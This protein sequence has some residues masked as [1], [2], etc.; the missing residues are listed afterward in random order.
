VGITDH[1]YIVVG[2]TF[3]FTKKRCHNV[4]VVA[5]AESQA[6]VASAPWASAGIGSCLSHHVEL[7]KFHKVE[8]KQVGR[9]LP[10]LQAKGMKVLR[11][12]TG[13]DFAEVA[14]QGLEV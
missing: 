1:S 14:L 11:N 6:V 3:R 8:A 9:D 5:A 12:R 10:V 2:C 4:P 13:K 7:L